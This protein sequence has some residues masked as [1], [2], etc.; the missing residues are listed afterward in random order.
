MRTLLA[1]TNVSPAEHKANRA[2]RHAVS[3]IAESIDLGD[4]FANCG[5]DLCGGG[6]AT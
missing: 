3:L 2:T 5:G 6:Q 4:F 1:R